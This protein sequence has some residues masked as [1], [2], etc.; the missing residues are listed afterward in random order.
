[1]RVK[2]LEEAMKAARYFTDHILGRGVFVPVD[3][4]S[5]R[6]ASRERRWLDRVLLP[7]GPS[8]PH[9]ARRGMK[10]FSVCNRVIDDHAGASKLSYPL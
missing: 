2:T 3:E 9:D 10:R 4:V 7:Q 5:A 1:M 6:G 8:A